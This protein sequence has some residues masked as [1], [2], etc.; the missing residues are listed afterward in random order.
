MAIDNLTKREQRERTRNRAA[1]RPELGSWHTI[2]ERAVKIHHE[3]GKVQWHAEDIEDKVSRRGK[4]VT[5][6]SPPI[7]PIGWENG[8]RWEA[9]V[10]TSYHAMYIGYR[11]KYNGYW[12]TEIQYE[13]EDGNTYAYDGIPR[14]IQSE[15]VEVWLFVTH[16]N[17]KPI[18]VFPF[19]CPE[20]EECERS[21]DE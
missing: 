18:E 13:Y 20:Y 4:W 9:E 19:E 17:R 2:T 15:T 6:N 8:W 16:D 1:R 7:K 10:I 21:E 3:S 11:Y 14:F 12:E 5:D